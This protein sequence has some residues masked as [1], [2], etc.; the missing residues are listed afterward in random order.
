MP[1]F[2][3]GAGPSAASAP[4]PPGADQHARPPSHMARLPNEL[5]LEVARHLGFDDRHRFARVNRNVR[6]L[7]APDCR[8][9]RLIAWAAWAASETQVCQLLDTIA[10]EPPSTRAV[11][12]HALAKRL[13]GFDN[14]LRRECLL[15]VLQGIGGLP[16][17]LRPTPLLAAVRGIR[18]ATGPCEDAIRQWANALVGA[19]FD[20][21]HPDAVQCH[22]E[23]GRRLEA[24]LT[25]ARVQFWVG[26]ATRF[27]P[28]PR[29]RMLEEVAFA[30]DTGARMEQVGAVLRGAQTLTGADGS[31]LPCQLRVLERLAAV[32]DWEHLHPQDPAWD[33]WHALIEAA[34]GF[35]GH[36]AGRLLARLLPAL[37]RHDLPPAAAGRIRA[38]LNEVVAPCRELAI[39]VRASAI[40]L[41]RFE[42]QA[43][44]WSS[45]LEDIR[46]LDDA[47]RARLLNAFEDEFFNP[48][49]HEDADRPAWEA[50]RKSALALIREISPPQAQLAPLQRW[51]EGLSVV[52]GKEGSLDAASLREALRLE[53]PFPDA[54][55]AALLTACAEWLAASCTHWATLLLAIVQLPAHVRGEPL[56]ALAQEFYALPAW[57]RPADQ[58]RTL[59][60]AA[61]ELPAAQ[62]T[63][64]LKELGGAIARLPQQERAACRRE[65]EACLADLPLVR[66]AHVLVGLGDKARASEER[67]WVLRMSRQLDAARYRH[68]M[69]DLPMVPFTPMILFALADATHF[70]AARSAGEEDTA[71]WELMSAVTDLEAGTRTLPLRR[72]DRQRFSVAPAGR[73]AAT[74]AWRSCE[75]EEQ[76][77]FQAFHAQ[78][79][80]YLQAVFVAVDPAARSG[81]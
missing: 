67:A 60:Q 45:F 74:A 17:D 1:R 42:L 50:L 39:F 5:Q 9:H 33:I 35:P 64:M 18:T 15:W 57:A 80:A 77:V 2:I 48:D 7:L 24:P 68:R 30:F 78:R 40:S 58:W 37:V 65:L 25:D 73:E 53:A 61:K 75:L 70:D 81:G 34:R 41:R 14:G 51:L 31:P 79:R 46:E 56:L 4:L 36:E 72:L 71:W 44:E 43:P 26:Y 54:I 27:A 69:D 38:R 52:G 32:I 47:A 62:R 6:N 28:K 11:V 13:D 16:P 8:R 3:H 59:V 19:M 21:G 76:A 10:F 22:V 29:A 63:A 55:R 20:T 12:L 23:L 66:R 49:R